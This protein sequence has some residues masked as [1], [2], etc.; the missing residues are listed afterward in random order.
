MHVCMF[1]VFE[2]TIDLYYLFRSPPSSNESTE[3]VHDLNYNVLLGA[4]IKQPV[5]ESKQLGLCIREV[6]S[7]QLGTAT[8]K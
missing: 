4:F 1:G 7:W 6:V 3:L 2:L 5:T 8:Q